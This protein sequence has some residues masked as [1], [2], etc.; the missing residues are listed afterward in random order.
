[1]SREN[2]AGYSEEMEPEMIKQVEEE[3]DSIS[4]KIIN[5]LLVAHPERISAKARG[6]FTRPKL[7][8]QP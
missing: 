2:F 5:A 1:M 7:F 3:A 6:A 4:G 8:F